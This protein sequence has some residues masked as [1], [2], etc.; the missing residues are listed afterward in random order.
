LFYVGFHADACIYSTRDLSAA[1]MTNG[2]SATVLLDLTD[3]AG[4]AD[5]R[6]CLKATEQGVY[7]ARGVWCYLKQVYEREN[8]VSHGSWTDE[9]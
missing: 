8:Y 1:K 9:P 3:Y 6:T 5:P 4:T 7:N 2:R